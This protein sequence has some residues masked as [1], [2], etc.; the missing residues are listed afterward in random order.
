MS[1]V[2]RSLTKDQQNILDH[3]LLHR[4]QQ[5]IKTINVYND[6]HSMMK[7]TVTTKHESNTIDN[8]QIKR[9]VEMQNDL[10]EERSHGDN[11]KTSQT[12][13]TKK[14]TTTNISN[15]EMN[16][17][18]TTYSGNVDINYDKQTKSND[19][20][21]EQ[22]QKENSKNVNASLSAQYSKSQDDQK[23]NAESER[24]QK[25]GGAS[26]G[27][28]PVSVGANYSQED[29]TAQSNSSQNKV[30]TDISGSIS[31]GYQTSEKENETKQTSKT[32]ESGNK[33]GL[34]GSGSK[35]DRNLQ[36]NKNQNDASYNDENGLMVHSELKQDISNK[37][38][39][40]KY[41]K[42]EL[43]ATIN[44]KDDEKN[45]IKYNTFFLTAGSSH[46]IQ[47][48]VASSKSL[49]YLSIEFLNDQGEWI[50]YCS[51]DGRK[52]GHYMF[53][54]TE[55]GNQLR[56]LTDKEIN[57]WM[58]L[59]RSEGIRRR[60]KQM[61]KRKNKIDLETWTSC[62]VI[63]YMKYL[64]RING[65]N[66]I[67]S[68]I[69]ELFADAVDEIDGKDLLNITREQL[70]G[71]T[72]DN[73]TTKKIW[74]NL[75]RIKNGE[76]SLPL[77]DELK[78]VYD[79]NGNYLS[80]Y[81]STQDDGKYFKYRKR[82]Q[83]TNGAYV[84]LNI[85]TEMHVKTVY[86]IK[87]AR[88][89]YDVLEYVKTLRQN[90]KIPTKREL[91]DQFEAFEKRFLSQVSEAETFTESKSEATKKQDKIPY[92]LQV[93][94]FTEECI[95]VRLD[96]LKPN[97]K[98]LTYE[99]CD[100]SNRNVLEKIKMRKNKLSANKEID[101]DS[102]E[103]IDSD[104]FKIAVYDSKGD[105]PL[106]NIIKLMKFPDGEEYPPNKYKPEI[107]NVKNI[108]KVIDETNN[109]IYFY[110][111][112]PLNTFGDDILYKMI[113]CTNMMDEKEDM[114]QDDNK[115]GDDDDTNIE[116]L[117]M[118]LAINDAPEIL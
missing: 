103:D 114:K 101:V 48:T 1:Q 5:Q 14:E 42:V 74:K 78:Q 29:E 106:S 117:P 87:N 17:K 60:K 45:E 65:E 75:Q 22:K 16:D 56:Q 66:V 32:D 86:N 94:S 100:C 31:G 85:F 40:K 99:I 68:N 115:G 97:K 49:I 102:I 25:G 72:N 109:K 41:T 13:N 52:E 110:W 24:H 4:K 36:Q 90:R 28:G 11:K 27:Y 70:Q 116:E 30:S 79:W 98:T 107:I 6:S 111:D 7:V 8:V 61:Q 93:S 95:T 71:I 54:A 43:E 3:K 20:T 104:S 84:L 38:S 88:E 91:L 55:S 23:A 82:F 12:S 77:M 118:S 46:T 59:Q 18:N 26:V 21:E 15:E 57:Q 53:E 37:Q 50:T 81:M 63:D 96:I 73:K 33:F 2:E 51:N 76:V 39:N 112:I 64:L 80:M 10:S 47:E 62:V 69:G 113:P 34:S 35:I 67:V 89:Q 19:T 9:G 105:K 92:F 83:N 58:E 44:F 108:I